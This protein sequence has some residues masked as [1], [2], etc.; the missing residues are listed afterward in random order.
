MELLDTKINWK[1]RKAEILVREKLT[2]YGDCNEWKSPGIIAENMNDLFSLQD[3]TEEYLFLVV[4]NSKSDVTGIFEISHGNVN[5]TFVSSREIFQKALLS[6][7]THIILVHNHPSGNPTPSKE[8]I[9]VTSKVYHAGKLMDIPLCDH[10]IIG[11]NGFF[12]FC[13][14][15]YWEDIT[16]EANN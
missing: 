1:T 2:S 8:D 11:K 15:E 9:K 10:I 4:E 7:G 3:K 14:S 16:I 5:A 6:C 13:D 12:S